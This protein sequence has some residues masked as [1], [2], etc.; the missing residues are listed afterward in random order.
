MIVGCALRKFIRADGGRFGP[1]V[2]SAG[3]MRSAQSVGAG[4]FRSAEVVVQTEVT[5]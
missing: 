2:S 5:D 1:G 4:R 3:K